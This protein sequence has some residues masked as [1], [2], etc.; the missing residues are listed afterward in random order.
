VPGLPGMVVYLKIAHKV[1]PIRA[2]FIDCCGCDV[3]NPGPAMLVYLIE[4]Q[5]PIITTILFILYSH[6]P[7]TRCPKIMAHLSFLVAFSE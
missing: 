6:N 2:V 1:L 4:H 5:Q 3:K 7:A